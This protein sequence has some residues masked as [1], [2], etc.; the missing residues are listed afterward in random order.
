MDDM[1]AKMGAILGNPEMMQKIMTLA[2]S[3]NQSGASP[4]SNPP[5]PSQQDPSP[6]SSGFSLPDIDP[7]MLQTLSGFAR[8]SGIDN[9]QQRLLKAL[10]PYLS[11]ERISKLEKAMRAAKLAGLA[12]TF[13]GSQGLNSLL[14]R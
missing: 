13:L 1:E 5:A 12:S 9:N 2:K 11:H 14:G 4:E 10:N 3:L 7:S 6:H 8:Q